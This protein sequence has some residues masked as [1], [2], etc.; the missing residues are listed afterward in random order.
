MLWR[1]TGKRL[2]GRRAETLVV[3]LRA[4]EGQAEQGTSRGKG[5]AE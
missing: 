1:D 5:Q 4:K 3:Q 2:I